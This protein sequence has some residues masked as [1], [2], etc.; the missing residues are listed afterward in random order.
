MTTIHPVV[1]SSTKKATM[2]CFTWR[3]LKLHEFV[4]E[5]DK[6]N[7]NLASIILTKSG[8]EYLFFGHT[9]KDVKGFTETFDVKTIDAEN[10]HITVGTAV[11]DRLMS[12]EE[13]KEYFECTTAEAATSVYEESSKIKRYCSHTHTVRNVRKP[14][15]LCPT[16]H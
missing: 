9:I 13:V 8:T 3:F 4:D 16:M 15:V 12:K 14:P 6:Y 1:T 11:F 5:R 2:K 7:E 10:L